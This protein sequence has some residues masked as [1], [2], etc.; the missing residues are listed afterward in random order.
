MHRSLSIAFTGSGGAGA[1]T[2]G[3][4]L[5]DAAARAGYYGVMT[6]SLGPQIRGGEAAAFLR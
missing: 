5:L 4:T 1:M 2:A 3:Q 6:R